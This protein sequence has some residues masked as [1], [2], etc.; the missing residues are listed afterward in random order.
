MQGGCQGAA[1]AGCSLKAGEPGAAG[2]PGTGPAL[3]NGAPSCRLWPRW[4]EP[5]AGNPLHQ[6]S[7]TQ[8]G[9]EPGSESCQ[10]ISL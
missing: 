9:D 8:R 10:G 1:K 6:Q 2:C 3:T 4:A 7:L 5:V